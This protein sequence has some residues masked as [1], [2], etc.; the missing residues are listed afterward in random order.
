MTEPLRHGRSGRTGTNF[1]STDA[2]S[3]LQL[4]LKKL[5]LCPS[6]SGTLPTRPNLQL[7]FVSASHSGAQQNSPNK[8]FSKVN[9]EK[10]P[11]ERFELGP[12]GARSAA[13]TTR[14]NLQLAFPSA[15]NNDN[16]QETHFLMIHFFYRNFWIT[17][18]FLNHRVEV[19]LWALSPVSPSSSSLELFIPGAPAR[20]ISPSAEWF[21]LALD[22]I[23]PESF[24]VTGV[25]FHCLLFLEMKVFFCE[26]SNE[27]SHFSI[28]DLTTYFLHDIHVFEFPDR[29]WF[30]PQVDFKDLRVPLL[31]HCPYFCPKILIFD[32]PQNENLH[33]SKQELLV[34][35][36]QIKHS[37][38]YSR[39]RALHLRTQLKS[40]PWCDLRAS[41]FSKIAE[42][43]SRTKPVFS[44]AF[45]AMVPSCSASCSPP[46]FNIT[47][48][49]ATEMSA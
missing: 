4:S 6:E 38:K 2:S 3:L 41:V 9:L 30:F 5:Q 10:Q 42:A 24:V 48:S 23:R 15:N 47:A 20:K 1:S 36:S 16:R 13:L 31:P 49:P 11:P 7:D 46:L 22:W 44:S 43:F 18:Q 35:C 8:I 32:T 14:P 29:C 28:S 39:K 37:Q 27:T 17:R 34:S 19:L 33:P 25:L 40:L 21:S 26:P 45:S 12:L